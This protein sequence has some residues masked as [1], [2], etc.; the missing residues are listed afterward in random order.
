MNS[1]SFKNLRILNFLNEGK[2]LL[3]DGGMSNQLEDQGFDLNNE[4]WSAHLLLSQPRAIVDAHLHYLNAGAQCLITASYQATVSGLIQS[5]L[6]EQ[7][8]GELITSSVSLAQQAIDE[9]L[10]K[11]PNTERPF[12]AA[13]IGPYGASLADGSEYHGKYGVNDEV[14]RDHHQA[15][16]TLLA[17]TNA[18][19]LECETI[20]SLQEA[21]ILKELLEKQIKPAWLS[22]S[23]KN[24][25]QLN[26]GTPI[27]E[28]VKEF[29]NTVNPI[30][31]GINCTNPKYIVE[32]IKR[33]KSACPE[34]LIVV[35]PNSGEDYDANSK[36][37]YGTSSP[38]ECGHAS[39]SWIN[40]GADIIGG[41][42]RM[43]PQHISSIKRAMYRK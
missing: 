3:L 28:C 20:P 29:N 15:Q 8:A 24:G 18:D 19:L 5:G 22:F 12:V 26:D 16:I 10:I 34:K 7:Q 11:N 32:L 36:A 42:C 14:L 33:I 17:Q 40:A 13:S 21:R 2:T 27:E 31:L 1:P 41:C 4:L 37:W 43:G 35:Y 39:V 25:Q 30:A 23:C 6:N 38:S 9:F